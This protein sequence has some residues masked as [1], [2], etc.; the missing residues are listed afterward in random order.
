MYLPC[1]LAEDGCTFEPFHKWYDVSPPV[2]ITLG[3]DKHRVLS[4][5]GYTILVP[6]EGNTVRHRVLLLQLT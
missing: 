4:Q 3:C 2:I 6:P 1:D 5:L